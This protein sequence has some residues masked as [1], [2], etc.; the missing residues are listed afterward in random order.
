M[1]EAAHF[2]IAGI[3]A[4]AGGVE[5]LEQ[6]FQ[7]IP[8][9]SGIA[10]IVVTHLGPGHESALP[11]ILGHHSAI[12]VLPAA[13]NQRIAPNHA[14]VLPFDAMLTVEGGA[15][16][17]RKHDADARRERQPIDILM[18]SLAEDAGEYAIGILLSGGGSDGTLG[19]KAIKQAGGLTLAQGT[20]GTAPR[21]P[22]MPASAVAAGIVDLVIPVTEI[23]GRLAALAKGL[24]APPPLAGAAGHGQAAE[25]GASFQAGVR[26]DNPA[27]TAT[28]V[29]AIRQK[30]CEILRRQIG[31]D[32]SGYKE[33]TFLRRVHRRMQVIQL[34]T[35]ENYVARL[36]QDP[37]EVSLLFRDLLIGVT[38][39][40][41]DTDAFAALAE[42]V[43][44]A[45]FEDRGA[46]DTVRVWVPGCA[47]GEEAYSIAMLLR[48]HMDGLRNVPHV[49]VFATDIDEAALQVARTGRY[50]TTL[51]ADVPPD[52][53]AQ[54][55]T[56]DAMTHAVSQEV[57]D[58]CV[59]SSHSLVRDPPF[60]RIDMVSCR[61]LLIYMDN[62]LQDRVFPLFHYALR[63]GGFLFLGTSENITRHE[64]LFAAQ[65]KLHRIFRRREN[66]AAADAALRVALTTSG[67]RRHWPGPTS[68]RPP[69]ALAG[70][71]LR[72][73]VEAMV[74]EQFAPA[75]V[76]VDREG[77]VVQQ[78]ARL[79]KYIEPAPGIPSRQ[80]LAMAR[81]GLRLELRSALR[82]AIET[83][84]RVV[85]SRVEVE[86][87]E[88]VQAIQLMVTPVPQEHAD[89][90]PL[91]LVVFTDLGPPQDVHEAARQP[92]DAER[93]GTVLNLERELRDARERLQSTVE[94]YETAVEELR[95]ANEE[96][97][98]VN[99]ELQSTNEEMETSKEEQQSIN[100]E[101]QTVNAELARKVDELDRAN[102][103]L[104]NLFEST[105]IATVFLDRHLVIR[106][107]TPAVAG[108]FN[109]IPADR[110]RP[111]TDL[112]TQLDGIDLRGSLK[113]VLDSRQPMEARVT[114]GEGSAHYLMR[115]LPYRTTD[116]SIDGV[117]LTFID[118]SNVVESEARLHVMVDELNHRVRN[119]LQVVMAIAAQSLRQA[120]SSDAFVRSFTGRLRALGRAHELVSRGG[121]SDVSLADLLNKEFEPFATS[122][123]RI[124]LH[125]PPVP[126][127]PKEALALGMVA[128]EMAT[129]AAKH[130]AL[131]TSTG[132]ITVDW[133]MTPEQG[134]PGAAARRLV[135]H[136]REAGGPPVQ[137]PKRRGFGSVLIERQLRHD[138]HGELVLEYP[139][140]GMRA[141]ITLPLA[142]RHAGRSG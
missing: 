58:L 120:P 130:G 17:L 100:E 21:H 68:V 94:E 56:R 88:R 80:L 123:G 30:I 132:R 31:H 20:D 83:R 39:F 119:T 52:L 69:A 126:L 127:I 133:E 40:F 63:Q 96:M 111:L 8:A 141:T 89:A 103:D 84:R 60:S 51:T 13:D 106:N 35:L 66:S 99:E 33:K 76:V 116:G 46:A 57:R 109:L 44:P 54:Y 41:R 18:A 9:D 104:R 36:R 95:S 91:F 42:K 125:G 15:L 32:F 117:L 62:E 102:A 115:V 112:A 16:K 136:W 108:I 142:Q 129:N 137:A 27:Q 11:A 110:G 1:A 98:S 121:W 73:T 5:A 70:A 53:L 19:M 47:T 2:P 90:E 37:D 24:A 12:P 4:S 67:G 6:F 113:S 105:R 29:A 22:N 61:N 28:Q 25:Q 48:R 59:F 114:T 122:A 101:L 26:Q 87:D 86:A 138:L 55:F 45:L 74:L 140:E 135:L 23:P 50:P 3:G 134:P 14:Y 38:G 118:V 75:H 10:F 71:D 77:D 107:F 65:D 64:A 49:Q 72:G 124:A 7:A 139:P 93:D 131:A 82:E 43:I 79:G 85:R 97:V 128:H 34:T 92:S 78:S 81:R